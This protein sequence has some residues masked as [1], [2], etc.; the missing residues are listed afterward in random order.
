[1][2]K[3]EPSNFTVDRVDVA[4][5]KAGHVVGFPAL[6]AE[7]LT[8]F[9]YFIYLTAYLQPILDNMRARGSVVG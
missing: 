1:M 8:V 3:T 9:F 6:H 5:K 2:L 4:E 7:T